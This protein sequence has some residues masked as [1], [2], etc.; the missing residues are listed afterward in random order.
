M[1][2]GDAAVA[3]VTHTSPC[4]KLLDLSTVKREISGAHVLLSCWFVAASHRCSR[5]I[6]SNHVR[7]VCGNV[8]VFGEGPAPAAEDCPWMA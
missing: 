3:Q 2:E 8:K 6:V 4:P 1:L 5:R 7:H